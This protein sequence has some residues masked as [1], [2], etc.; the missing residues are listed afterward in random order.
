MRLR[1][2]SKVIYFKS[3]PRCSVGDLIDASDHWGAYKECLQCG[4]L[5]DSPGIK[6]FPVNHAITSTDD[7]YPTDGEPS[8]PGSDLV[9]KVG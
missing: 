6:E 9:A 5:N 7:H 1:K 4:Y 8:L 2:E 3:C